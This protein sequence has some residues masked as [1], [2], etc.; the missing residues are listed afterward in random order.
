MQSINALIAKKMIEERGRDY[1]TA[2]RVSKE[3]E[4][5][6]RGLDKNAPSVPPQNAYQEIKQVTKSFASLFLVAIDVDVKMR[7]LL[8]SLCNV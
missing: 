8:I 7:R 1:N 3:Y 5:F 4:A 6:T 2:R